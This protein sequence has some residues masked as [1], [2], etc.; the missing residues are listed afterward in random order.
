MSTAITSNFDRAQEVEVLFNIALKQIKEYIHEYHLICSDKILFGGFIE[1]VYEPITLI[2]KKSQDT[3]IIYFSSHFLNN[4]NEKILNT[5]IRYIVTTNPDGGPLF[6]HY[7][8]IRE[9]LK[10]LPFDT[11][12]DVSFRNNYLSSDTEVLNGV[13][14][15]SC[16]RVYKCDPESDLFKNV[17]HYKCQ[18]GP[19]GKLSLII[20]GKKQIDPK[21]MEFYGVKASLPTLE[22]IN[23][24]KKKR[25]LKQ[26]AMQNLFSEEDFN[27]DIFD[28]QGLEELNTIIMNNPK[29][30]NRK[31]I[32]EYLQTNIHN[33]KKIAMLLVAFPNQYINAYRYCGIDNQLIIVNNPLLHPQHPDWNVEVERQRLKDKQRYQLSRSNKPSDIESILKDYDI[34]DT[35][36]KNLLAA[37]ETKG[38]KISR[39]KVGEYMEI[40]VNAHD[41]DFLDILNRHYPEIYLESIKHIHK[42]IRKIIYTQYPPQSPNFTEEFRTKYPGTITATTTSNDLTIPQE[43]PEENVVVQDHNA[44]SFTKLN[45]FMRM[46]KRIG[47]KELMH[48]I[49]DAVFHQDVDYCL[50]LINAF[51]DKFKK[52]KSG[53]SNATLNF[54]DKIL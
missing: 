2:F 8:E 38:K 47:N 45:I 27:A 9:E 50:T 21:R 12:Y 4:D 36:R 32:M 53:F 42:P 26:K 24:A 19:H 29:N 46:Y 14:C 43:V 51:E 5:F 54:L 34:S 13:I 44:D 1:N 30:I 25:E 11:H 40:A 7:L 31:S 35:T 18:C 17:Q 41:K 10:K 20:D 49:N 3:F 33:E 22:D 37:L 6:K 48:E 28:P 16:L 23:A 39:I 15:E 52:I